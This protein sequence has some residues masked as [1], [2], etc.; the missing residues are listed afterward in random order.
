MANWQSDPL[1]MAYYRTWR[2]VTVPENANSNLPDKN[3]M[4]MDQLPQGVD[5]AM[6]F[7]AGATQG[8]A[9]WDTLREHYLPKLHKQGDSRAL[10]LSRRPVDHGQLQR[11]R[12]ADRPE[13]RN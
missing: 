13:A 11:P 12:Q 2:D 5:V 9:F 6:V 1:M 3:V 8:T 10:R 4:S 7:D